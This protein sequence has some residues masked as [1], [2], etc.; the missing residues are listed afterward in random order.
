MRARRILTGLVLLTL[1]LTFSCSLATENVLSK[2]GVSLLIGDS[3]LS[4][5][6]TVDEYD[7]KS[8]DITL[9]NGEE[10]IFSCSWTPQSE[11]SRIFVPIMTAGTYDIDV[12]HHGAN[13]DDTVSVMENA[14]FR[15]ELGI[16]TVIRI[17]P[18]MVG[19]IDIEPMD[20][21]DPIDLTGF[22]DVT[23]TFDN[24]VVFGPMYTYMN[25]VGTDVFMPFG[26]TGTVD[27]NT[28][29]MNAEIG[30]PPG[31]IDSTAVIV[32]GNTVLD[33]DFVILDPVT[34]EPANWGF[35]PMVGTSLMVRSDPALFGHLDMLGSATTPDGT[36]M[37]DLNTDWAM[38]D[39]DYDS[40]EWW[41]E[42]GNYHYTEWQHLNIGYVT[43]VYDVGLWF[44]IDV[45]TGRSFG[46]G[47]SYDFPWPGPTDLS[48]RYLVEGEGIDE[49]NN[50]G[51][52]L[53]F[54]GT[55]FIDDWAPVFDPESGQVVD[56]H[57]AGRVE[58]TGSNPL[59]VNFNLPF[60]P[61]PAF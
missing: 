57:V 19:A 12:T 49:S 55:L 26:M 30:D 15:I 18:G 14:R 41:D 34:L 35:G 24:G 27:G 42:F 3:G 9:R 48:V 7:V 4:R 40:E 43:D 50:M 51:E 5:L 56:G 11:N 39:T 47:E 16:I 33:E 25:Q 6:V 28:F 58:T 60:S 8:L 61:P 20:E 32:D 44:S 52:P 1:L 59:T 21:P 45:A 23:W 22:W 2:T 13:G 10:E 38:A 17:V 29:T 37:I 36:T 46:A 54:S 31:L 53:L